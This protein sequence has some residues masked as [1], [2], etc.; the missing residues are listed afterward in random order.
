MC[1]PSSYIKLDRNILKWEWYDDINTKTVFIHLLLTVNYEPKKWHG[2]VIERGHVF[3][4]YGNIAKQLCLSYHNVRTALDHLKSTGEVA[5]KTTSKGI[6]ITVVN[7]D[8]F[9]LGGNQVANDWQSSGNQVAT[10]KEYKEY[11]EINNK[12]KEINKEKEKPVIPTIDEVRE[13][14]SQMNYHINADEFWYHYDARN[15]TYGKGVKLKRWKSAVGQ[16]ESKWLNDH[17][18]KGDEMVWL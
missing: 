14:V 5:I 12:E 15:W 18:Q 6:E 11:K 9:Q 7:Y 1:Q 17:P 2:M 4:S 13:Y 8:K 10:T 3:T 16:W